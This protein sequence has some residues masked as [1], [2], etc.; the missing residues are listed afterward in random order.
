MEK[1][2]EEILFREKLVQEI[3]RTVAMCRKETRGTKF[4]GIT[5]STFFIPISKVLE[6]E[7]VKQFFYLQNIRFLGELLLEDT[8]RYIEPNVYPFRDV[9]ATLQKRKRISS[10]SLFIYPFIRKEFQMLGVEQTFGDIPNRLAI[11]LEVTLDPDNPL[12]IGKNCYRRLFLIQKDKERERI[13]SLYRELHLLTF[14]K[15]VLQKRQARN[16]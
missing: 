15:Y 13:A 5:D 8:E 7:S 1:T 3:T 11:F 16:S 14:W 12:Q 10:R 2:K 9:I 4:F 6:C